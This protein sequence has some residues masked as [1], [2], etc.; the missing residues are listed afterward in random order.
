MVVLEQY[1]QL[2]ERDSQLVSSAWKTFHLFFYVIIA[3]SGIAGSSAFSQVVLS[4]GGNCVLHSNVTFV[5]DK[6]DNGSSFLIIDCVKSEWGKQSD[7]SFCQYVPVCSVIF[8]IVWITFFLMCGRGGKT[9][10]GLPQPWRIVLPALIFNI[11]FLGVALAA[12]C[13]LQD[14]INVFCNFFQD[15]MDET[16]CHDLARYQ[17]VE[18]NT[19]L[20]TYRYMKAA[21]DLS[22][23]QDS[24]EGGCEDMNGQGDVPK[25]SQA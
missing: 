13:K 10:R 18:G 17:L 6:N 5:T 23:S 19:G 11:T 22:R 4:F 20:M 3:F 25:E 16:N 12:A 15:D 2:Y 9:A 24:I 21:Q 14:G 8:S 7:C 1:L